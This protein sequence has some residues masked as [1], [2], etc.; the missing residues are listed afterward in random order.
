MKR[1]RISLDFTSLLDITMI[2]LFWFMIKYKASAE[3]VR[4]KAQEQISSVQAIAAQ[5]EEEK[6][7]F[8]AEK[9]N[10]QKEADAEFERIKNADENAAKNQQALS[11]FDKG[12]VIYIKL[13]S[14]TDSSGN[15]KWFLNIE[16]GKEH[17]GRFEFEKN[18][19]IT[20]E[21]TEIFRNSGFGKDDV[22]LGVFVYDGSQEGTAPILYT[23]SAEK[24][25]KA[26]SEEYPQFYCASIN[27]SR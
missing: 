6:T 14:E 1:S 26:V 15:K 23:S 3:E 24:H 5:L 2:I 4:N 8:E 16:N 19:D 13:D 10:W 7:A 11:E 12:S 21:L 9:E 27:I 25:I 20:A 22:M 17:M 18:T